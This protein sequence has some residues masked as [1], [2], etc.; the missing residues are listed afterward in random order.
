V[1]MLRPGRTVPLVTHSRRMPAL[2]LL[3]AGTRKVAP[4]IDGQ[5]PRN[6]GWH[7]GVALSWDNLSFLKRSV[8]PPRRAGRLP[9]GRIAGNLGLEA[10]G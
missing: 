4:S 7:C 1:R 3:H 5:G 6:H 10:L 9:G 2:G 8:P